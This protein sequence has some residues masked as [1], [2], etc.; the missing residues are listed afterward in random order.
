MKLI[1]TI[2][3]IVLLTIIQIIAMMI[4]TQLIQFGPNFAL[5][6]EE[7]SQSG[8]LLAAISTH[9]CPVVL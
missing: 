9:S 7:A 4:A 6:Q 1:K 8:S 3:L 5:T 2:G